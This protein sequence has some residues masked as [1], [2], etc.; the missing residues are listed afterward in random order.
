MIKSPE[1]SKNV[2][3]KRENGQ[4]EYLHKKDQHVYNNCYALRSRA[5]KNVCTHLKK[6]EPNTI[7]ICIEI[8]ITPLRVVKKDSA[9]IQIKFF[10][11]SNSS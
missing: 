6:T 10:E 1:K 3:E 5:I 2:L 11:H 9:S 8:S 4:A 7:R